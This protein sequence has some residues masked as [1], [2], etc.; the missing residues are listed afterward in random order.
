MNP[1]TSTPRIRSN[2]P[3]GAH[4]TL[5]MKALAPLRTLIPV[6]ICLTMGCSNLQ[7][8]QGIATTGAAAST[9]L[10]AHH[11][12]H[13]AYVDVKD[14]A[15]HYEIGNEPGG[16]ETYVRDVISGQLD[17]WSIERTLSDVA[18]AELHIICRFRHRVMSPVVTPG[19]Q[20]KM[21]SIG[22]CSIK[23][24]EKRTARILVDRSWEKGKQNGSL[25]DFIN[26]V[27]TGRK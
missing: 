27:L 10:E 13:L 7:P 11:K 23:V 8:A 24:I 26:S 3:L 19:F 15:H 22:Q 25:E 21:T 2:A 17:K 5:N 9:R 4:L 12:Y 1:T 18:A 14:S 16:D 6:T 20:I